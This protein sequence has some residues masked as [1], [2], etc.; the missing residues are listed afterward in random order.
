[1][2]K[3]NDFIFK[4]ISIILVFFIIL[5][6]GLILSEIF[7]KDK[8]N[9][10]INITD[11]QDKQNN[12]EIQEKMENPIVLL[13]TNYGEIKIELFLNEAPITAG[14]FKKLVEEGFYDGIKFHRVIPDFMIQG[15]DP[16]SKNDSLKNRWGMGGSEAIQDEFIS[17]L[18]N[19]RGTLSMANAGPNTGSSQFFINIVDNTFLDFDK[20][21][22]QSK[23][24]VFG[25]VIEGMGVVDEIS[26]VRRN[27][28]DVPVEPVIINRA[29]ILN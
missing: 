17:G 22:M 23:H 28:N 16:L 25:K 8:V 9:N 20:P 24:P 3:N 12:Q 2:K 11:N 4:V 14:N 1:M 19:T 10:A 27:A 5:V 6:L 15:G 26:L 21:P 13:E 18:S 29:I 7:N